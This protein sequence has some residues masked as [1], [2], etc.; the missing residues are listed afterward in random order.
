[1]IINLNPHVA[2]GKAVIQADPSVQSEDMPMA[3]PLRVPEKGP[4]GTG[5]S[6]MRPPEVSYSRTQSTWSHGSI[7]F[8]LH[9]CFRFHKLLGMERITR[10]QL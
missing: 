7:K 1:M 10:A 9:T 4:S 3:P 2:G 5:I 6:A 8:L